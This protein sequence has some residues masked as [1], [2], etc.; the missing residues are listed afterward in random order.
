MLIRLALESDF[1][2]VVEFGRENAAS[3]KPHTGFDEPTMRATLQ[4]YIDK[5]DPVVFV[6][7]QKRQVIGAMLASISSYRHTTGHQVL[8]EVL[9]VHPAHRGSRAAIRL[10]KHVIDWGR[11]IGAR[12]VIGGVDNG[13]QPDRTMKFY[14]HLGFK[15]VGYS[16]TLEI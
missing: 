10:V 4:Q 16:M 3:T 15:N 2:T 13:F 11:Q 12:E 6:A 14:E 9:Y 8:C 7:E 5:A 1:D